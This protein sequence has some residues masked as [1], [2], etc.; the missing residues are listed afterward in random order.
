MITQGSRSLKVLLVDDH[1]IVREGLRTI[2]TRAGIEVVGEA[3]TA[4]AAIEEAARLE[5]DVV[6]M[7]VR[8]PDGSGVTAC[9]EIR[10]ANPQ[11][12]VLFLTTFKDDS[13]LLATA[14]ASASGYLLKEIG[15]DLLIQAI[16]AVASGLSVLGPG[17][18]QSVMGQLHTMGAGAAGEHGPPD[19]QLSSQQQRV[20]A[21]VAD[22]KTNKEI[23]VELGLSPKTVKNYLSTVFEKLQVS[24]RS[25]AVA[26][27]IR[28]S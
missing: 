7:D 3:G 22:G 28:G 23:A 25:E 2:I 8:L 15:A 16:R 17:V 10:A 4:A 26:R 18:V 9:R 5:P 6:L 1:H 12:R 24:R 20:L 27:V 11:I 13:A 14:F 21:L 19:E